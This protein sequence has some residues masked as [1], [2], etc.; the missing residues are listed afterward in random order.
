MASSQSSSSNSADFDGSS[1]SFVT[2]GFPALREPG[3]K[4][5]LSAAEG[6]PSHHL[7][8]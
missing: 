5:Y 1:F 2:T 6:A 8:C 4:I 7:H 3:I